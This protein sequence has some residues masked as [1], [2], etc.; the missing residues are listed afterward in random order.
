MKADFDIGN[1]LYVVLTIVFLIFGA[2]GKKKKPAPKVADEPQD[3]STADSNIKFQLE[4]LFKELNPVPEIEKE[5]EYDYA[6]EGS[7]EDDIPIDT[8]PL[9]SETPVDTVPEYVQPIDSNI[10]YNDQAQSSLD[11]AGMEEGTP[12]FDYSR[13]NRLFQNGDLTIEGASSE[14]GSEQGEL[15]AVVDDFDPRSAFIYSEIFKRKEF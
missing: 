6:R 10:N 4:D 13:E 11:T 2:L 8:V 5:P 14:N 3:T 1:L 12:D 15:E 9:V 7:V